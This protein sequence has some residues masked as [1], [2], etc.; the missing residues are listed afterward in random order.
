M[1]IETIAQDVISNDN[2]S[3]SIVAESG[4]VVEENNVYKEIFDKYDLDN[5][6]IYYIQL[7]LMHPTKSIGELNNI[8]GKKKGNNYITQVL[9]RPNVKNAIREIM[10]EQ[11]STNLI[12]IQLASDE[13]SL[14]KLKDPQANDDLKLSIV[15]HYRTVKQESK[16][17]II[18][19]N[20]DIVTPYD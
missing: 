8:L 14:G 15:K 11:L 5:T 20:D 16:Q 17:E 3:E 7:R 10:G 4:N 18:T 9:N 13:W 19:K 2:L 6:E 12:E 1:Q